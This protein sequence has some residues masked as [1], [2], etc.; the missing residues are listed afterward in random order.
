VTKD[1][2]LAV[3]A[4]DLVISPQVI[5]TLQGMDS[6]QQSFLINKLAQEVAAQ[7]LIEKALTARSLLL[8]GSQVPVIA[9]N[10]PA[11]T[12]LHQS[13]SNLDN[14]IHSITFES[15]VRKDM[16]SNTLAD[17]MNYSTSQQQ[18]AMGIG[19]VTNQQPLMENSALPIQGVQSK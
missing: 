9:A 7:R 6:S 17:M 12:I 16:V 8:T 18:Q 11:Q 3:S 2:L 5:S 19:K 13:I 4:D 1:N 15:Q 10:R 14:Q